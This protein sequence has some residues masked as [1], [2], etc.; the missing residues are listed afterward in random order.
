MRP[1]PQSRASAIL[2]AE[3]NPQIRSAVR[4]ILLHHEFSN[5]TE[6]SDSK[7]FI[8]SARAASYGAILLDSGMA[9]LD[10]ISVTR[11]IRSGKLGINRKSVIILLAHRSDMTFVYEAREAGVTELVAKPFS[12]A[13]LM[14]R[15]ING[16]EK[17]RPF[18]SSEAYTGPCRRTGRKDLDFEPPKQR[19]KDKLQVRPEDL[20][21]LP[22][23]AS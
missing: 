6:A 18:I 21:I 5:I 15:L 9:N 13:V 14:A 12:S 11:F 4:S 1:S 10:A 2:L 20:V 22:R 19:F 17:P 3:S 7:T 16:L 8:D 23:Q